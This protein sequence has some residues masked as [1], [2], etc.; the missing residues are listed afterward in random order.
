VNDD[1][2]DGSGPVTDPQL[3]GRAGVCAAFDALAAAYD[4]FAALEREVGSR[5]LERLDFQRHE[6][7]RIIDLGCGTG[8]SAAALK[9]RYRKA[10]VIGIDAAPAMLKQLRRRSGFLRPLLPVCAD[11]ASVPIA[12]CTA[13]L[14][15]SNLAFQWADDLPGLATELR[16]LLRPGGML[17][18]STLGPDSL[19][20]FRELT[21]QA[22]PRVRARGFMDLH[23]V[24]DALQAAGYVQPV[25]DSERITLEYRDF[26]SL[27]RDVEHT[28]AHT[29]FT[30][31]AGVKSAGES[32][33]H[34]D[35]ELH[36]RGSC[37]LTYEIV[38]GV[39]FGPQEGQPIK[40]REGDVASFSVDYLRSS[41]TRR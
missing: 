11:Y 19:K 6:P 12:A 8:E 38:Y 29:H 26:R 41:R 34:A 7:R 22:L 18:F 21:A 37:A 10:E 27:L 31:W 4:D 36:V 40:S 33:G 25:M 24:G 16:P 5:L 35:R 2:H 14:L 9:R 17:L 39:A 30:D 15:F 3:P 32:L 23:D 1:S 13:D 20:E 28:G